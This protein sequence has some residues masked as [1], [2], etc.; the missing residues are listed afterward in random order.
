MLRYVNEFVG[1]QLALSEITSCSSLKLH[2]KLHQLFV[3]LA[4]DHVLFKSANHV[5]SYDYINHQLLF[6]AWLCERFVV[7]KK[8]APY[9]CEKQVSY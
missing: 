6:V 3:Q 9:Y 7:K 8:K 1:V 4:Y 2:Y 5:S